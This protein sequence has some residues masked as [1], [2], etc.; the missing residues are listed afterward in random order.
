M[1]FVH[2][3]AQKGQT[4]TEWRL[5]VHVCKLDIKPSF[6]SMA[7]LVGVDYPSPLPPPPSPSLSLFLS[8]L[9]LPPPPSLGNSDGSDT[10]ATKL[11][12]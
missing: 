7:H 10:K 8:L 2:V 9:S 11:S 3:W 6:C 1:S 4:V 5:G 12:V